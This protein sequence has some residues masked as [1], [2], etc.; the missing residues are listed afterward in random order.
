MNREIIRPSSYG[1][2]L[3]FELNIALA[4]RQNLAEMWQQSGR[5]GV[6]PPGQTNHDRCG[7]LKLLIAFNC[8]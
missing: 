3:D 6:Y 1:G 7:S 2:Q 8:K 4:Y 5:C